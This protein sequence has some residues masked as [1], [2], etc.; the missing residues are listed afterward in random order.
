MEFDAVLN[1][2]GFKQNDNFSYLV[3][4]PKLT[5][6]VYFDLR[7][8]NSYEELI[9]RVCSLYYNKGRS[10]VKHNILEQLQDVEDDPEEFCF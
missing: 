8:I 5:G 2:I 10:V 6:V 7:K 3:S 4:H 1:Q 9:K